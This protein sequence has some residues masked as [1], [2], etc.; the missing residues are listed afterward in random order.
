MMALTVR[1][2]DH[3]APA[4]HPLSRANMAFRWAVVKSLLDRYS[5]RT[6]SCPF[7]IW[8][9]S[10]TSHRVGSAWL[11]WMGPTLTASDWYGVQASGLACPFKLVSLYPV[12][13][14]FSPGSSGAGRFIMVGKIP[15]GPS[16]R[17]TV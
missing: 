11:G 16:G 1:S 17:R 15:S 12:L 4:W 7:Q 6:T 14:R 9:T 13:D 10:S 5:L 2:L 8:P 3:A